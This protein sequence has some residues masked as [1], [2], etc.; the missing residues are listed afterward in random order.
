[1]PSEHAGV[2]LIGNGVELDPHFFS[3]NL[4]RNDGAT[5]DDW[6]NIVIPRIKA[7]DIQRFRVMLQPHWWE[8]YNDNDDPFNSSLP[9]SILRRSDAGVLLP[10]RYQALLSATL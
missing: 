8:P 1:M 10:Y 9:F 6:Y 4:T 2:H 5:E 3:Q 7:M